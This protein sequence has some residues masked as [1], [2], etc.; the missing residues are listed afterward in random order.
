MDKMTDLKEWLDR[1]CS[2]KA[3]DWALLP[4]IEL[5][6]DQVTSYLRRQLA[7]QE[8]DEQNPII[9]ANMIN[10]YAKGG[11]IERSNQKR[12]NKEQLASL[13]MLCS[14]KQ[15]L[16]INDA[17]LLLFSLKQASST[18]ALYTEFTELQKEV[19]S[20]F[21]GISVTDTEEKELLKI[22]LSL[23]LSSVAERLI[24]ERIIS[25]F[26]PEKAEE[27][28]EDKK[29]KKTEKKEEEKAEKKAEKEKKKA[30]EESEKEKEKEKKKSKEEGKKE[31]K[32]SEG[33]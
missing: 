15:A 31:K 10:N 26:Y 4:D 32:K 6:M 21:K 3:T 25:V 22:A 17:S 28:K 1:F 5:Y 12:Y 33:K 14:I 16:S 11:H 27:E 8:K 19:A 18:E 13:Y 7:L 23:S 2:F 30:K 9:T 29:A 20:R 24:A